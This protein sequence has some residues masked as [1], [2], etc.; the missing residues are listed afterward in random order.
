MLQTSSKTLN[1][2]SL[3]TMKTEKEFSKFAKP[4]LDQFWT[5][6][7]FESGGNQSTPDWY[8]VHPT[9]GYSIWIELKIVKNGKIEF[10]PGQC[11]WL[12]QHENNGGVAFVLLL[13][14]NESGGEDVVGLF[15]ASE[16]RWLSVA[17]VKGKEELAHLLSLSVATPLP[18]S[19]SVLWENLSRVLGRACLWADQQRESIKLALKG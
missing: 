17:N 3:T 1:H 2:F 14:P 7:S 5:I 9:M 18:L 19:S 11:K 16:S 13:S 12:E 6:E 15:P 10:Q 8:L 4:R